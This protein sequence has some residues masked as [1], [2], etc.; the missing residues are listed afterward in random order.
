MPVKVRRR[1]DADDRRRTSRRCDRFPGERVLAPKSA[2][3]ADPESP[4]DEL[5]L[6]VAALRLLVVELRD[7]VTRIDRA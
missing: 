4:N 1:R 2:P 7:Q 5:R 6:E 3:P